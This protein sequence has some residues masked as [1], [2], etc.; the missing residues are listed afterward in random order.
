MHRDT[1]SPG[2]PVLTIDLLLARGCLV[3]NLLANFWKHMNMRTLLHRTGFRKRSGTDSNEVLY[4]LLLWVWMK[5]DSIGFFAR[6]ALQSFSKARK[7]ALYEAMNR[8]DWNWRSLHQQVALRTL[9]EMKS[10]DAKSPKAL[11][12]D[13]SIQV[14]HGKKMP[15]VSSHFDHTTGKHVMGQQMLTLGLSSAEGFVPLD[16][17]LFI[18]Q[19]N[20]Q[21]L[22]QPFRDGRSCAAQRY[23]VAVQQSK[24]QMADEMIRRT[25]R[26][27]IDAQYLLTDAWFGNKSM[28]RTAEAASLTP[29][30]RM[31]K[32]AMKYRV[33]RYAQGQA[34]YLE[35]DAKDLYQTLVRGQWQKVQGQPYQAKAVDVE[36]DLGSSTSGESAH[37]VKARLLFVRGASAQE[38][39]QPG[40]HDWVLF[41]TTDIHL[42]PRRILEL[43][44]LRW[45]IEVYFKEAKQHLGLLKEQSN[46]YAAY[47]A[48][49][50]LTAI[51]FC[52]LVMAKSLRQAS[53][54][55]DIRRQLSANVMSIH[56]ATQLWTVFQA[57]I[58]GALDTLKTSLGDSLKLVQETI[59]QQVQ[60]FFAQALQ[61]EPNAIRLEAT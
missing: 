19:V 57:L 60:N 25:L 7:D 36:L 47:I 1:N 2:L 4:V 48:S 39:A 51:R 13:D 40:K 42:E 53:G 49:I 37:W 12:L 24:L 44:A 54:I 32:S 35:Q 27:G 56:Y 6:D 22:H 58:T 45:A 9:R 16:C 33:M 41:L 38:K 10:P 28:L 8:E 17:E 21:P 59:E 46:H 26:A 55:A 11:V 43:Y 3:D 50:H 20:A 5:A 18:S 34:S 29:I 31:K 15:G 61:L 52:F 30:L 14:R 23:R